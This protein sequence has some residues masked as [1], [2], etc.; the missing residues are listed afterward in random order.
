MHMF[1]LES[2]RRKFF[3]K[4]VFLGKKTQDI[5]SCGPYRRQ[6]PDKLQQF[7][8]EVSVCLCVKTCMYICVHTCQKLLPNSNWNKN[9][10]SR[11]NIMLDVK[12]NKRQNLQSKGGCRCTAVPGRLGQPLRCAQPSW[13][14]LL[15]TTRP[16]CSSRP[17][18]YKQ[19]SFLLAQDLAY[20]GTKHN[21]C[22][23]KKWGWMT[24]KEIKSYLMK[25]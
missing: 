11:I 24:T 5:L 20:T 14:N 23:T 1:L 12:E 22:W 10:N 8:I 9:T 6:Y 21:F 3:K 18:K 4:A 2:T 15:G 13:Q 25:S 17:S 19:M 7:Q 16:T